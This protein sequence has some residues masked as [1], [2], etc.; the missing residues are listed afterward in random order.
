LDELDES[1]DTEVDRSNRSP[2]VKVDSSDIGSN[3]EM[4]G[5]DDK[6]AGEDKSYVALL[7]CADGF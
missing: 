4:D 5:L 7:D 1:S 2:I 6:S 3:I